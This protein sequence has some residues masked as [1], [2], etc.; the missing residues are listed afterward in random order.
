MFTNAIILQT[1]LFIGAI[2]LNTLIAFYVYIFL[3]ETREKER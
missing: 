1:T 2:N 3:S